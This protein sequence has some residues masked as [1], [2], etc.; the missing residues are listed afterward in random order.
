MMTA[1]DKVMN[2]AS[3]RRDWRTAF[4]ALRKLLADANDTVQVFRILRALNTDTA[5]K[6]YERLLTTPEGGRIAYERVELAELLARPGYVESF[7]E[8]S[9]GAAYAEFL[10][11]TGYSARG[12]VEVS[13][14]DGDFRERLAVLRRAMARPGVRRRA[15]E[16][17]T[18]LWRRY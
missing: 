8:G 13:R 2:P 10:D 6:G 9:V 11:K 15:L 3:T 18:K 16:Y 4:T 1:T 12:L 17:A 7:P 14:A 5:K